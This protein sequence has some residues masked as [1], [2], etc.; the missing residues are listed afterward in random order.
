MKTGILPFVRVGGSGVSAIAF[1][2]VTTEAQFW[3]VALGSVYNHEWS[4][5]RLSAE[6]NEVVVR[7]SK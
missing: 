6:R 7:G 2:R 1:A 4:E 3:T 5:Y